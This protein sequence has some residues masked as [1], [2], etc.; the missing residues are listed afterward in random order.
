MTA[1]SLT[2]GKDDTDDLFLCHRSI[3]ALF[4]CDLFLAVSIR[5]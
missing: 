5:E 3:C 4:K 1:R 2:A